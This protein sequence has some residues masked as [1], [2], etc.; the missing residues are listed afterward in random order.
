MSIS[1]ASVRS[2]EAAENGEMTEMT[3]MKERREE[4]KREREKTI[5][6][7]ENVR[8]R[9]IFLCRPAF[10]VLFLNLRYHTYYLQD[11]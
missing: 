11:T 5:S 10:I 4:K 6:N 7:A 8:Y 1:M 2:I 9:G 3:E